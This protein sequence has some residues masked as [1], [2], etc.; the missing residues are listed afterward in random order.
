MN[1]PSAADHIKLFGISNQLLENALDRV[2]RDM[3]LDLGR[4]HQKGVQED[5]DYYP[6]IETDIRRDAATM[7]R[8]YE[9]FYSLE[10]AIRRLIVDTLDAEAP[11]G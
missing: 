1:G 7:A 4:A 11:G 9:V 3:E 2:E 5:Q 10:N 8:H 6:Q